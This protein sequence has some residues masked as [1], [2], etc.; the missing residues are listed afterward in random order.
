MTRND[1]WLGLDV[2]ATKILGVMV[3]PNGRTLGRRKMASRREE[4]PEAVL[5]RARQLATALLEDH[6]PASGVGVGFAGLVDHRRGVVLSSIM[7]PGWDGLALASWCE[8][9]FSLPAFVDN[10]ANASGYG[11]YVALGSPPGLNLVL[12]TVGTGIGGAIVLDGQVYRGATGT[13][14][15]F[16]NTTIDWNGARCWCGNQGCLNTLASGSAI[17][18]RAAA[19]AATLARGTSLSSPA[20]DAPDLATVDLFQE[21]ARAGDPAVARALDEGAR[22][23]G[24]G[25]ANLINI[26]NPDRVVLTGGVIEAGDAFLDRA[27]EEAGRRAMAEPFAHA[28]IAR[29][30]L[31]YEAGAVGAACLVRD[32]LA[33]GRDHPRHE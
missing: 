18:A 21:A 27:R 13:A 4:G 2:G 5:D 23:L 20:A 14:A 3:G 26:F 16:G 28:V 29:S 12:L 11:E 25:I 10:D 24:A 7:L 30:V 9:A 32:H 33:T 17:A 22:A 31:G 15:E 6:G 8:T 1:R 19:V